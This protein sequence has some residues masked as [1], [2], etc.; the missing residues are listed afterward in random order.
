MAL[1]PATLDAIEP[2]AAVQTER[3]PSAW[4]GRLVWGAK[5]AVAIGLLTW[6]VW[7]GKLDFARLVRVGPSWSMAALVALTFGSMVLPAWRWQLL[8]KAQG[9]HEPLTRILRLT[10]V[11]YFGALLLPGAAGG[12]VARGHFLLRLRP[13]A[14]VRALSTVLVDR[15]LGV[16]SLLLLG[17][18]S[19]SWLA[20]QGTM[21][22]AVGAMAGVMLS[23]LGGVTAGA[24]VLWVR[25]CR[26]LLL[27]VLPRGWGRAWMESFDLYHARFGWLLLCLLISLF[28]NSLVVLSLGCAAGCTGDPVPLGALF[29][30]GPLVVL[31]N[32]IP[33][34]P[35]GI[36]V[37]ETASEGLF[38]AFGVM[39][40]AEMML[41]VRIATILLSFP[42]CLGMSAERRHPSELAE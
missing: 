1:S 30:A 22:T 5:V 16:Y 17:G 4:R 6:L 42:G 23:L 31:A 33:I 32:C 2:V 36:G 12:D 40:G 24:L 41:L 18:L 15:V 26:R 19:V 14:R 35:G 29:L 13:E 11:G 27:A 10:W 34:S 20:W 25:P 38:A 39:G 21:P 8:L 28:S 3:R 9:L 7:S 37:A